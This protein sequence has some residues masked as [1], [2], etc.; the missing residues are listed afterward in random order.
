MKPEKLAH[1]ALGQKVA[2]RFP[3]L[4]GSVVLQ[5]EVVLMDPRAD[6]DGHFPVKVAVE[7]PELRIKAGLKAVVE[8]PDGH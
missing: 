5:G 3:Q 7:N 6:A 1:V 2:V 4:E 8:L